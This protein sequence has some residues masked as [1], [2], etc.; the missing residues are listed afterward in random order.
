MSDHSN[1]TSEAP[2]R[3][4]DPARANRL[5]RARAVFTCACD[6]PAAER[7]AFVEDSCGGD[8]ALVELVRS[9]LA[10]DEEHGSA[11]DCA[12]VEVPA[13]KA[14]VLTLPAGYEP[15][16][17]LGRGGIGVVHLC[18][19]RDTGEMVAV[20]LVHLDSAGRSASARF[21]REWRLLAKLR[22]PS[23]VSLRAAGT[24][25]GGTAYLVMDFVDGCDIRTHC[26]EQRVP[27]RHRLGMLA[28]VADALAVAHAYGIVH[29]DIKPGNILVDRAERARL[30]DFGAARVSHGEMR[31]R[32]EHTLT[33]QIVGTLSY[34]SPEQADGRSRHAD[35]RSD[36]YQLGVVA[37]ELMANRMPHDFGGQTSA[38]TLRTIIAEPAIPASVAAGLGRGHPADSFFER[39]LAKD[40]KDR[41]DSAH[42]MSFALAEL[43]Q[44]FTGAS[45]RSA[46]SA[47]R[48]PR[49]AR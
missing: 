49:A 5:R 9:L 7:R 45:S 28:S 3:S 29:R 4:A 6:L 46:R 41:F 26:R 34:L 27:V 21:R 14:P 38:E 44:R 1:A 31:S 25:E 18:R 32:N 39:A 12:G 17:E 13:P 8:A 40:P 36:L 30:I 10:A 20:K 33:G 22:H 15:V 19:E 42:E 47:G 48:R 2:A 23:L 24:L 37:Y 43:A 16:R 35:H 11:W